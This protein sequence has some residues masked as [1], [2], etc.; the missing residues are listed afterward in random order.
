MKSKEKKDILFLVT[1]GHITP[2]LSVIHELERR[3]YK[4]FVWV[5]RM[6]TMKSDERTSAEY[7][8]IHDEKHIPF[9]N[10]LTGKIIRFYSIPSFI[11]FLIN[12][13]KIII[14]FFQSFILLI[15][16]KP[17]MIISFGGYVPLPLVIVGSFLKIPS[18]THE[19]TTVGGI[20]N[21]IIARFSNKVLLSWPQSKKFF[22]LKKSILVGNPFRKE[23]F[24][25]T[26][27][28]FSLNNKLKTLYITG[29]NQGAHV[30][31]KAV[32][33]IIPNLLQN[34]NIIHQ[35]GAT[36]ITNDYNSHK[37][38]EKKLYGKSKGVYIVRDFI[39]GPAIGEAFSKADFLISRSGANICTEILAL[40]KLA[41]LIPIPWSIHN[42]QL[43]NAEMLA[44]IGIASIIEEN[45]LNS[46]M[47]YKKIINVLEMIAKNV[48]FND[49]LFHET[50]E[51]SKNM[52]HSNAQV[53][54]VDEI[55]T[56]LNTS[57]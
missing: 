46:D 1:G 15:R 6:K 38:I 3:R 53:K 41:I 28:S 37:A 18:V 27:N 36:T 48:D 43:K 50:I 54:I 2:A 16:L 45:K 13:V 12:I 8:V 17:D 19:Q 11:E 35:T 44:E 32:K 5:G 4:R 31:N 56:I 7:R 51:K 55:E 14:G 10:S 25:V 26:T 42:E 20:A 40:A 34:I 47:L 52:V 23:I 21:K 9:I 57:K 22:D 39:Y 33:P 29:G 24:E 49:K 30:I